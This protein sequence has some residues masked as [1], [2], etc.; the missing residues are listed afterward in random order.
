M[1]KAENRHGI[2]IIQKDLDRL[3]L[4]SLYQPGAVIRNCSWTYSA[5]GERTD[6]SVS[7]EAD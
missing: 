4:A 2:R 1:T 6:H 5:K 3:K 7:I